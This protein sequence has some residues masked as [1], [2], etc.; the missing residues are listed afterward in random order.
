MNFT[1]EEQDITDSLANVVFIEASKEDYDSFCHK[2]IQHINSDTKSYS[3][4]IDKK[5]KSP[6][7]RLHDPTLN[8][9]RLSLVH[10]ED[11]RRFC[12]ALQPTAIFVD[13]LETFSDEEIDYLV[14]RTRSGSKY[15]SRIFIR[16]DPNSPPSSNKLYIKYLLEDSQIYIFRIQGQMYSHSNRDDLLNITGVKEEF[17]FPLCLDKFYL[18]GRNN[19]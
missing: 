16:I 7:S 8:L 15:P 3:V 11:V 14:M 4:Y 18:K 6:I 13:N 17:F 19:D 5:Y 9:T 2:Y 10:D 1:Q 12:C